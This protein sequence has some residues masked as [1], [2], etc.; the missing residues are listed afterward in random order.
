MKPHPRARLLGKSWLVSVTTPEGRQDFGSY[1]TIGG[2]ERTPK[3]IADALAESVW[4]IT[5]DLAAGIGDPG[6]PED[7]HDEP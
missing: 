4:R 7:D 6:T 3:Q 5:Y 2:L 1:T